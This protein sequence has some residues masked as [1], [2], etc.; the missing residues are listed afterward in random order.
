MFLCNW[1]E[2]SNFSQRCRSRVPAWHVLGWCWWNQPL[3]SA[4][5]H[6][7]AGLAFFFAHVALLE[8]CLG[9]AQD[10]LSCTV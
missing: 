9:L 6:R 5:S 8:D 10:G 3:C 4:L 1:L 2:P 7:D